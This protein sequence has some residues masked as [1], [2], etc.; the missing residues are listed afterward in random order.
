MNQLYS[1]PL[2]QASNETRFIPPFQLCSPII[3]EVRERILQF[4]ALIHVIKSY[5]LKK[6]ID[7]FSWMIM[8]ICEIMPKRLKTIH[9]E[10]NLNN[11]N[12]VLKKWGGV[13]PIE[14]KMKILGINS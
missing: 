4:F 11:T 3:F 10:V 2:L 8:A 14:A 1:I 13:T 12:I 9:L 7:P 5:A 6:T